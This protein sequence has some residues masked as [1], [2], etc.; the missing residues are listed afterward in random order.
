MARIKRLLL[1]FALAFGLA[2][3]VLGAGT[4]QA[5]A[6]E[7]SSEVQDGGS[8]ITAGKVSFSD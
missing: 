6:P 2:T 3:T 1:A 5:S 7:G 8:G 4:A